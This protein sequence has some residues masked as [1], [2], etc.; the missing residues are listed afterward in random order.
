[1]RKLTFHLVLS[2]L[3]VA[4]LSACAPRKQTYYQ[5]NVFEITAASISLSASIDPELKAELQRRLDASI[6]IS[7]R[8][9]PVQAAYLDVGIL[10]VN[11]GRGLGSRE[12]RAR[13]QVIARNPQTSEPL[14]LTDFEAVSFAGSRAFASASLAEA[15][16]TRIRME[17]ALAAP[18]PN[19]IRPEPQISTRLEGGEAVSPAVA[20]AYQPQAGGDAL[21]NSS[22]RFGSDG[23]ITPEPKLPAQNAGPVQLYVD[24]NTGKLTEMPPE[25]DGEIAV[26]GTGEP[27]VVTLEN[28]CASDLLRQ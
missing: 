26:D 19:A 6:E 7:H 1:M 20:R 15:I 24:E 2:F 8:G 9:G 14:Y 25:E 23:E 17:F 3:A 18:S 10:N 5:Q 13:V 4:L 22:T 27:C 28:D 21:L 11:G 12:N 16:A